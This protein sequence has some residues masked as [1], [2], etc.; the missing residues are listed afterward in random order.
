[1]KIWFAKRIVD[2]KG[3]HYAVNPEYI[4]VVDQSFDTIEAVQKFF[5]APRPLSLR[6]EYL[7]IDGGFE[8]HPD[9]IAGQYSV[10]SHGKRITMDVSQG[11]AQK[12]ERIK[13]III[14]ALSAA[15]T[16][17]PKAAAAQS[18]KG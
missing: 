5:E 14:D 13:S 9:I 18:K 2:D 12:L 7:T 6:A 10:E 8:P 11:A 3:H 17:L 1:V 16:P 4:G 15:L